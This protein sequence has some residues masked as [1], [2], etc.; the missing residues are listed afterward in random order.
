MDSLTQCN[1][2]S[3]LQID[4]LEEDALAVDIYKA[5]GELDM[6]ETIFG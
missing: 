2:V 1:G 6:A 4:T 3:V 5:I